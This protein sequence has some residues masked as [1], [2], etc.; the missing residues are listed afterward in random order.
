MP[1]VS[2]EK[3]TTF[4]ADLRARWRDVTSRTWACARIAFFSIWNVALGPLFVLGPFV[5]QRS[6]GGASSWGAIVTCSGVGSLVGAAAALRLKPRRP[7]ATGLML[8]GLV[9]LEPALLAR[10]FPTAV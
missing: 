1:R 6:L 9:A 2:H 10:P 4:V 8:F 7:L 3:Q 5:A